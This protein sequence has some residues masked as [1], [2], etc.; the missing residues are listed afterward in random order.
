MRTYS[1]KQRHTNNSAHRSHCKNLNSNI[2]RNHPCEHARK[3]R[4][5]VHM[6]AELPTTREHRTTSARARNVPLPS[7]S[8]ACTGTCASVHLFKCTC[9][10]CA[11]FHFHYTKH[12]AHHLLSTNIK[13]NHLHVLSSEA[14]KVHIICAL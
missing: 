1:L 4:T 9:S 10:A 12:E 6:G 11:P 5:T 7:L 3:S 13:T 2:S 14:V 8:S